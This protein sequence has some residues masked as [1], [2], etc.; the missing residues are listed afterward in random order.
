MADTVKWGILGAAKFAREHMGPAIHS[1]AGAELYA[2]ATSS[3]EKAAPFQAFAPGLRRHDS[4]EA[5]LADPEVEA[6]YIP[7]PNHLHVE[8]TL[9]ALAAGKH[10]LCEKPMAMRA[11][12]Y[13]ALISARDTSGLLAAEAYMIL[14]H[15]QWQ[16]VH[17][18]VQ[19]GEVGAVQ[20]VS[21]RF[22]FDNRADTGNI[23]NRA[24]T[25][26][27]A[28][29]DIGVYVFGSARFV[30]GAEAQD[31]SAQIR[32][33]NGID[34]Q[35]HVQARLGGATYSAYV[36]TRMHP[37][38]EMV[39]HGERGLIRLTA[40]FNPRVFGEARIELHRAAHVGGG[41][42]LEERFP[43]ADH[44]RLQVEAF[45]RSLR[46]GAAYPCPLEFSRG[47]QEMMDQVFAVAR[48]L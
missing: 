6:V 8:W 38:Q 27:G 46:D 39:F 18:M 44:Y 40:P 20:H 1:A 30:M 36:S 26:G 25:G 45:G 37:F 5:L 17:E 22:S 9:K 47:T 35:S 15:P 41:Q 3:P 24:E 4:Y 28:L 10:V 33:E 13:D 16:R 19:A 31:I 23:R 43:Q 7:L 2:L 42:V 11:G 14:H 48:D 29:R 21:G 34:V 12:D 32:W